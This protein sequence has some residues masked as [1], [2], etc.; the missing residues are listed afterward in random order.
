[1]GI[2]NGIKFSIYV[3]GCRTNQYEGEAIAAAL[4]A[5]GAVRSR[6]LPEA[7]VIVSCTVT[8]TADSKCR[9]L[10][11]RAR[12]E[13]PGAVIAVCGCY[14]QKMTEEERARLGADIVVGNR[15]K[16]LLPGLIEKS[17]GGSGPSFIKSCDLKSNTD[18]DA[19][20]LDR[21]R[22]HTRAFLKVQDGCAHC[23]SYC[24][25]PSVRGRP[26]SRPIEDA[27]AE[28]RR[29]TEG[30]CPEIVLT[31][32][33][34]GLYPDLP[35]LVRK[36]ASLPGIKRIRFGS[37][38]P[39]AVTD[40]LLREL[41]ECEAFCRHL[42]MPLQ[43]GDDGVLASMRRGYSAAG[44][45]KI[46]EQARAILGEELH[47]STALMVGFPSE[48]EKAFA[49]SLDF[50]RR[51]KFGKVHVF[52]YSRRPGTDAAA[53]PQQDEHAVRRRTEEALRLASELHEAFCSRWI[54]RECVILTEE[55]DGSY[56]RGLTGNY[57]RVTAKAHASV[58]EL[59]RTVPSK[60]RQEGLVTDESCSD[61]ALRF[62]HS[63]DIS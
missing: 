22:L 45:A 23:C 32:V 29:I 46:A 30:G 26:V 28:A 12:R 15:L 34:L 60:Y 56:A 36:I 55:T 33:H 19:L 11:R 38:E 25:V 4:E 8:A 49:R 61:A 27:A 37:I 53:M 20:S 63:C 35:L 6:T 59:V 16:H 47:I 44:F 40:G 2:L 10:I 54:G 13:H 42:H 1:M 58:N 51:Q 18:W 3:Q 57:I 24:I 39:F 62:R 52:P 50:V 5:E 17:L 48:D 21:P 31:G 41:A 7:I 43:S 9:K 14:A